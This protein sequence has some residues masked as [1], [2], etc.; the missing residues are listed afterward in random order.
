MI[1]VHIL[2]HNAIIKPICKRTTIYP[3][4]N[5]MYV[6]NSLEGFQAVAFGQADGTINAIGVADYII[7]EYDIPNLSTTFALDSNIFTSGLHFATTKKN[8]ILRDILSKGIGSISEEEKLALRD[9]WLSKKED[10]NYEHIISLIIFVLFLILLSVIWNFKLNQKVKKEV[11]KNLQQQKVMVQQNKMASM[12]EMIG[13]IAHQWRQPLAIVNT[14]IDLLLELNRRDRLTPDK[15]D[16]KLHLME[17]NI[18]QMSQTIEDFLSFFNPNKNKESFNLLDAVGKALWILKGYMEKNRIKISIKI[19]DSLSLYGYKEEYIQVLITIITNSID[20]FSF[21]DEK[22]LSFFG[23]SKSDTIFL[24]V[25][26]NAG[27]ISKDIIDKVFEPYFTTKHKQK[28]TGLGLYIA[29]MII[30]DS[31]HGRLSISDIS[32]GTKVTIE[33]K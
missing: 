12:G 24:E 25:S 1:D 28:G 26:D 32:N 2:R 15:L 13:N 6:D 19:D 18:L 21:T 33:I 27:G 4:I 5:I 22:K 3:K 17:T 23:Y 8:S 31:M 20:A 16:E 30:E 11:E 7:L 29:K 14:V 10:I 9:K